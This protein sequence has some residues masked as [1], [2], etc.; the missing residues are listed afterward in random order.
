MVEFSLFN[1]LFANIS[2][3]SHVA[4]VLALPFM[5]LALYRSCGPALKSAPENLP[6]QSLTCINLWGFPWLP[7]VCIVKSAINVKGY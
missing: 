4:D 5:Y 1:R 6:L 7:P 3:I 2:V